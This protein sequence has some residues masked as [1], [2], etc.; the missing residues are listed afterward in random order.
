LRV[1]TKESRL[2]VH[3]TLLTIPSSSESQDLSG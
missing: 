2:P 1:V 3:L